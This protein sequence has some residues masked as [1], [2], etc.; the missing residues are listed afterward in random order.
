MKPNLRAA[1]LRTLRPS[2]MT[3]LPTPSPGM[4]AILIAG[5]DSGARARFQTGEQRRKGRV[6]AGEW[7]WSEK[8]EVN[9][10]SQSGGDTACVWR[11]V[12]LRWDARRQTQAASP[13]PLTFGDSSRSG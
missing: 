12:P 6:R 11:S 13:A 3:S 10:G 5:D 9:L 4:T 2:G 7:S 1:S 8:D